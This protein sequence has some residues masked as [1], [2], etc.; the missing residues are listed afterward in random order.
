MFCVVCKNDL[1]FCKCPD[2]DERL[3]EIRKSP[4]IYMV[5]CKVCDRHIDRCVCGSRK[6]N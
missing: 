3:R 5:W 6:P 4:N 2:V 1:M